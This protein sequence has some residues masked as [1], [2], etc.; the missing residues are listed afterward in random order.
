MTS[1]FNFIVGVIELAFVLAIVVAV[2]AF[3]GYNRLR[4]LSEN[5]KEAFSNIGVTAKKQVS[6]INQ[7][8]DAVKGYQESEKLVMLKVSD[9]LSLSNLSQLQHQSGAVLTSIS[10]IAQRFPDLK[11][12]E[13]YNKLMASIQN[14]ENQ[15][16]A[17][18]VRYNSTAKVYNV[19]RTSIPDVFYSKLIGFNPAPYLDF[20]SETPQS[21]E[22]MKTLTNDDGEHLNA[23]LSNAGNKMMTM[24]R[25]IGGKAVE[26]GKLLVET[27]QEK[28]KQLKTVEFHY[29]DA[30]KLPKGPVSLD[31]L[32]AMVETGEITHETPVLST[33]EREWKTYKEFLVVSV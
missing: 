20:E 18:R 8:I 16:E 11:S 13:Q 19:Q 6:L 17:Q 26:Q 14:I 2:I 32:H 24:G 1:I 25:E 5:V 7:L 3:M 33:A 30:E 12:N 23:L 9:D 21:M 10:G 15:L 22:M 29:L 27:A 28:V 4:A 31:Q